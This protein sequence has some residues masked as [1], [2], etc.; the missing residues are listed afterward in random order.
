[1]LYYGC[2]SNNNRLYGD[3]RKREPQ[4][5]CAKGAKKCGDEPPAPSGSNYSIRNTPVGKAGVVY[6]SLIVH[7][8]GYTHYSIKRPS[9]QI[10]E[11]SRKR[12]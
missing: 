10:P 4:S 2:Q 3:E 11:G 12:G 9:Q 5:K 8:L 6:G 1:M 7:A